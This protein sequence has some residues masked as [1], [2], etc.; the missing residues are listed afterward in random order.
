MRDIFCNGQKFEI[1]LKF[2]VENTLNSQKREIII[3]VVRK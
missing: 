1:T 3:I 2:S